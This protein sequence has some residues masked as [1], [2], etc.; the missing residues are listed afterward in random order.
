MRLGR[1]RGP[2]LRRAP[3]RV[4]CARQAQNPFSGAQGHRSLDLKLASRIY[5]TP[6]KRPHKST[7]LSY[8]SSKLGPLMGPP[9]DSQSGP[10]QDIV[11]AEGRQFGAGQRLGYVYSLSCITVFLPVPHYIRVI[12]I[13]FHDN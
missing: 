5:R 8:V 2:T 1:R 6:R 10:G 12:R 9:P 4:L 7:P 13:Y 3:G 11:V